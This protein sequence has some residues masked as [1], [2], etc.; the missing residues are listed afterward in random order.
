MPVPVLSCVNAVPAGV[1][2]AARWLCVP[3][4]M[5][6]SSCMGLLRSAKNCEAPRTAS[7]GACCCSADGLAHAA[8]AR[9]GEALV[10]VVVCERATLWQ[11]GET[12]DGGGSGV[13]E[14]FLEMPP[15][16]DP[17]H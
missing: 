16:R 6:A 3:S 10:L 2:G 8:A 17:I 11:A 12:A 13:L 5:D 14:K 1:S 9:Q 4:F 15:L 7:F